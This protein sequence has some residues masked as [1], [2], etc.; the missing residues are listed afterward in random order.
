MLLWHSVFYTTFISFH[1][2]PIQ[3]V[4]FKSLCIK[5]MFILKTQCLLGQLKGYNLYQK[6]VHITSIKPLL[7]TV[8]TIGPV[9]CQTNGTGSQPTTVNKTRIKNRYI[10]L[11]YISLRAISHG[12]KIVHCSKLLIGTFQMGNKCPQK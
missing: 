10:Y 6:Y 8:V 9:T 1:S 4:Y 12:C 2:K 11:P 3:S 7:F 5:V